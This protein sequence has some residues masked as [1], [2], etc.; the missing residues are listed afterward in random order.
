MCSFLLGVFIASELA[1]FI[2]VGALAVGPAGGLRAASEA[3]CT[4]KCRSAV[5]LERFHTM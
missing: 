4:N 1:L 5:Q 3:P 2:V